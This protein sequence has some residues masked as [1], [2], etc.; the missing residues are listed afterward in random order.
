[1]SKYS[2]RYTYID[3]LFLDGNIDMVIGLA[4]L[5]I[6]LFLSFVSPG[7]TLIAGAG[8]GFYF[9]NSWLSHMSSGERDYEKELI[10]KSNARENISPASSAPITDDQTIADKIKAIHIATDFK[11]PSCGAP[12]KPTDMNCKSCGS[13]LVAAAN[14]P[15]PAR[16]GDVEVGRSIHVTHPMK[17]SL[18]LSVQSR[19]YYGELWQAQMKPITDYAIQNDFAPYARKFAA[20]NQTRDVSFRYSQSTWHIDDIGKFRIEYVDGDETQTD[21]DAIGRFIH[22]SNKKRVL[23]VEDYETGGSGQDKVWFGVKIEEKD[24]KL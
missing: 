10:Y 7:L 21:P 18:N 16:W 24:I 17:G 8:I 2:Q 6:G 1:M 11:C 22:A 3:T 13:Y 5:F 9:F 20:S 23:V 19:I 4:L 12:L 14:L 15:K